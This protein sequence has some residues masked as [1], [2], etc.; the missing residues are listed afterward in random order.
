M[1]LGGPACGRVRAT[2][3]LTKAARAHTVVCNNN[4]EQQQGAR[5]RETTNFAVASFENSASR[6]DG[7]DGQ[8]EAGARVLPGRDSGARAVQA[9]LL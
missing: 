5:L 2:Q 1:F 9:W 7:R 3:V 4:R 8:Q 6:A